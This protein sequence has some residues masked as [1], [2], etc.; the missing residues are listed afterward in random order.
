MTAHARLPFPAP[1]APAAPDVC[2]AHELPGLL[3]RFSG[4]E[5]LS[6]D[7][8]D[9]LLWRDCHAPT[10]VF[11]ALEGVNPFQRVHGEQ[12][13]RTV[14][15]AARGV[16]EVSIE[17]IYRAIMPRASE[18]ERQTAI[19]AEIAAEARHCYAFAPTVALMRAARA[20]CSI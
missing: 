2:A 11:A 16:H 8:F 5:L 17:D 18:A 14:A 3:D 9:T 10:D 12:R 20:R 15:R 7:C 19:A 4:I 6:L 13:A 1:L